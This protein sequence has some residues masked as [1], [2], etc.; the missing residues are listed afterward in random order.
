[1]GC[2]KTA[3]AVAGTPDEAQALVDYSGP[4]DWMQLAPEELAGLGYFRQEN[5]NNCH[6]VGG[7]GASIGP[8][9]ANISKHRNAAWRIE[10]FKNP[11]VVRP[12]TSMPPMGLGSGQMN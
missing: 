9:L 8:D 4:T 11:S 3:A 7:K 5:C 12:G 6:A 2:F 10:H 1:M